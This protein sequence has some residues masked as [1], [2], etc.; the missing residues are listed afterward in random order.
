MHDQKIKVRCRGVILHEGK[1]LMV[2]HNGGRDFFAFPGGH[3]DFGEDPKECIAR[4]LV[5]ELGIIPVV[6]RLLYVHSLIQDEEKQSI[7]FFFEI[8]NG[9]DYIHHEEKV[10]SHAHEIAETAWI[11]KED[12]VRILPEEVAQAFR[13]GTLPSSETRFIKG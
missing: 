10:K 11:G 4:E 3:L 6:G 9:A 5:E 1:L 12:E 13:E 7:E 2:R 8:L